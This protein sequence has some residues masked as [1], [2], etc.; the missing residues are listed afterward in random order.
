MKKKNSQPEILAAALS[1]YVAC[2]YCY[3]A[4]VC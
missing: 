4:R 3:D 2:C 1:G